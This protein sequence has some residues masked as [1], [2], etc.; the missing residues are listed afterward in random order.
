M[1]QLKF[2]QTWHWKGSWWRPLYRKGQA[3]RIVVRGT[4]NSVLVEFEDGFRVCTSK[5]AVRPRTEH[6]SRI[7][8]RQL[9]V[10]E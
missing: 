3:C 1:Q 6:D 10:F 8:N 7:A 2:D 4:K 9:G 5:W